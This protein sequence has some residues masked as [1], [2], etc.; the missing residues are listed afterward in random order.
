[1]NSK[2]T[3]RNFVLCNFKG[4]RGKYEFDF[5]ADLIL[6]AGKNGVGKSSIIYALDRLLNGYSKESI[7][8]NNSIGNVLTNGEQDGYIEIS[9]VN[10]KIELKNFSSKDNFSDDIYSRLYELVSVFYQEFL[11]D[12]GIDNLINVL[13]RNITSIKVKKYLDDIKKD[14]IPQLKS[15]YLPQVI[16]KNER[17]KRFLEKWKHFI[18]QLEENFVDKYGDIKQNFTFD[19]KGIPNYFESQFINFAKYLA[20]KNG[21]EFSE[22]NGN[23]LEVLKNIRL[24]LEHLIENTGKNKKK[25]DNKQDLSIYSGKLINIYS[26]NELS[27]EYLYIFENIGDI[28][29][30]VKEYK[31]EI[32]KIEN[33][34]KDVVPPICQAKIS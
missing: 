14:F 33:A 24:L 26:G 21:S 15:K 2:I 23:F 19:N 22:Q 12:V 17:R 3:L 32:E 5:D 18:S 9:N 10:R 6:L 13:S 1:M 29:N 25:L 31:N 20:N 16:N 28:E 27:Y 4:F 11:S 7:L 30:N 8:N 34:I